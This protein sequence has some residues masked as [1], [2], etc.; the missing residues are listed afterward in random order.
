MMWSAACSEASHSQFGE[1]AIPHLY[2]DECYPLIDKLV[3]NDARVRLYGA[4]PS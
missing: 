1:G 2:M 3:K 4:K